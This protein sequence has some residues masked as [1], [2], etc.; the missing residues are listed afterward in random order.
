[1][2]EPLRVT[3]FMRLAQE[4]VCGRPGLTTKEV[5]EA[6][7]RLAERRGIDTISAAQDP[8]K[9]LRD[10]LSKVHM[11]FGL[12]RRKDT[13]G[14]YRYYPKEVGPMTDRTKSCLA[15]S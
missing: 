8:E 9:S 1:M 13:Q 5:Y 6:V 15:S 7:V 14:V 12:T 4:V 3:G 10:T 11:D 2:A